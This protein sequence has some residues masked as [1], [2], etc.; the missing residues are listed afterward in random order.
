MRAAKQEADVFPL[1]AF[2]LLAENSHRGHRLPTAVPHKGFAPVNSNTTT[3][4]Q[5]FLYDEGRRSRSTGKERDSETGLDFFGA[6]YFSAAQ[7]RFT[8]ADWSAKPEAVPY[9]SLEDPQTLNLYS[10]VRNNPLA[11]ADADGHCGLDDPSGCTLKQFLD[12]VP[13]RTIGGLKFEANAA[14]EM[15]GVGPKF[16]ASN[17]EQADA[18]RS[19]EEVK[20]YFQQGLAMLI[21]GPK[22]EKGVKGGTTTEP[23]LPAK[24]IVSEEGVTIQ[25][26]TRSGDHGPAHLH[27]KGE[28]PETRIGQMGNPLKGDPPLSSTQA[29]VVGQNKSAIRSSVDKI[30]R[31]FSYNREKGGQ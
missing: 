27:V 6:R 17:A 10:Y 5:A 30:M 31:W 2:R 25:H 3:G 7:G 24:T 16:T 12:S 13:D 23:T 22:G 8:S 29:Q 26:Y 18:M 20:P 9:S 1:A 4:F 11:R 15:I 21:P 14:L 28:G 19:G